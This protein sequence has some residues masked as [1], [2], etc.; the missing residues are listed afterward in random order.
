MIPESNGILGDLHL[1]VISL[2][3]NTLGLIVP[4]EFDDKNLAKPYHGALGWNRHV[5]LLSHRPD[6]RRHS[7]FFPPDQV[8]VSFT[9]T[10]GAWMVG[11][12]G[13]NK[14]ERDMHAV[15]IDRFQWKRVMKNLAI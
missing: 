9:Q 12:M 6:Q 1:L 11:M 14:R 4:Q 5:E 7:Q 13:G 10:E 2:A 8:K 15:T 3:L